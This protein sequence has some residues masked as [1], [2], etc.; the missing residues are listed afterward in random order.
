MKKSFLYFIIA[1]LTVLCAG[2]AQAQIDTVHLFLQDGFGKRGN[3]YGFPIYCNDSLTV[4]DSVISGEFTVSHN[5]AVMDI[6][7]FDTVGTM[8]SGVQ[9]V[10]YYSATKKLAFINSKPISGTGTLIYLTVQVKTNASGTTPLNLTGAMLNEGNPV[11]EVDPGSFRPMDIFINPKN[12][13]QNKVVGDTILF[14]VTGDKTLPL[15]WSVAD[16][17]IALIDSTGRLIGKKIGQ[18]YAKVVD[19]I[20]LSDSSNLIPINSPALNSLTMTIRDTSFVQN[21]TFDLPIRIS[22]VTSLGIISTQWKLNFNANTLVPKAVIT[23][24]ALAQ[25]WG[26]PTVN[27]GTGT[28]DVAMA[29]SDTLTSQ[30]IFAYVRFQ[31]KRFATQSSNLT[32]Q[33]VMFNENINAAIQ[34]GVFTPILGPTITINPNVQVLTRGDTLT[35]FATGGTPPYKWFSSNV[36]I[37][38]VDSLTGKVKAKSR[39]IDTLRAFDVQG[40]DGTAIISINDFLATLPDTTVAI[41]DSVDVPIYVS[42]V[43]GLGILSTQ[44]KI[45]YD[46]TKVRFSQLITSG[47]MSSAM[48]TAVNDSGSVIHMAF[49]GSFPLAGNG[50]F[51]KLRFHHKAPSGPGQ[52]TPLTF[53]EYLNNEN[54]PTVTLKNGKITIFSPLNTNPILTKAM[55]DTTINED[56]QLTFDYDAFDL[57]N[58]TLKF[59]LQNP[60]P[61][62][63]IDSMTGLFNWRPSFTQFGLHTFTLLVTDGKGGSVSKQTNINVNRIPVFTQT[64]PDTIIVVD[65]VLNFTYSAVD[66]DNDNLTFSIIKSPVGATIQSDGIFSWKPS[67]THIGN[68]TI[69]VAVSDGSFI[70][71]DSAIVTVQKINRPPQFVAT[72][73]DISVVVDSILN[74]KYT[75][76]DPDNDNLTFSMMKSPAGATIQPDGTFS[77][78]PSVTQIG[79]DTIIIAVSDGSFTVR[80]SAIVTVQK[81]NRSPQFISVLPDII[82]PVDSV[83][84]FKYAAVDPDN[85]NLV[86]SIVKSLSGATIQNDGLFSWKPSVSQIGKD[87]IIIS[88]SD[89]SFIV[90]DT[91]I[92]TVIGFPT[93]KL[94]QNNFDFGSISFGGSKTLSASITNNGVTPLVILGLPEFNLKPDPNFILDTT[95]VSSIAPGAQKTI[96]IT[97]HPKSVGGHFTAYVFSTNDPK[98]P[99][100]V[101]TANGSAIAKLAV[102][103]KLLVD[104]LHNSSVS[105]KDSTSGVNQLFKFF[106]QS[107]IQISLTGF[108]LRPSGND[109]LLLIAPQKKFTPQEIDSVKT[110]VING[111]LLV[112]LGNSALEGNNAA[113]LNSLLQDSTWTTNL[114]FNSNTVVDDSSNFQSNNFDPLLTTFAD[115]KHPYF[116]N[117]DTLVFFGS[118]SVTVSGTAIPLITTSLK[119]KTIG[120]TS[121]VQPA[122]AGLSKIGKGKI[123]LLGD[124]D[125]WKVESANQQKQPNISIKDNL[126]FAINV[127]SVTEDY[128]V[129]LPN[130]TLNER[131]QLV[132]IPFDLDNADVAS[133]LKGLGEQGPLS[134]RLFGHYDPSTGKYV[135]FPTEKFKSFKRGEAYW[136]ITRGE[137]GL[138]L[139][140]STIVPVQSYYPIKIGPGY[141]MVGN[142]FPYKVSWKN[143]THDSTQNLIWK[144]DGATF[145]AESLAL[146]PFIGYFVKNMSKDSV[147]IYINPEDITGLGKSGYSAA[148]VNEGEWRIGISAGSGKS[149]DEEN[150]AGVAK[151]AKDE[152]D[153]FDVAEPPSSPTD[154]VVVRFQN[155]SWKEQSGS[156]AMDI[157]SISNEGLFWDFDVTT[158]ASQ[159]RV[160]LN[161]TKFGNL[162]NDFEIFVIDKTTERIAQID[163]TYQYEFSMVKNESRRKFRLITGKKDYVEKNTQGIP[164]IAVDYSLMQNYPNPFNPSTQIR[165]A[166]GHSGHVSLDVYNVLGQHVRSLIN[167]IQPIGTYEL[168]WDGKDKTGTHV[169]SGVYFYKITVMSNGEKI[170]NETKKLMLL[171]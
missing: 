171:K 91:A 108:D 133:V 4:A 151:G 18:T 150:Y 145:K 26:T 29:G 124:A 97:Y 48:Q 116:A 92:V 101:L 50:V 107:G 125:M 170:F 70:A 169:S 64:L 129:K 56:Q 54:G 36:A 128:E 157:R 84:N 86:F 87:T 119:G 95:G 147:I 61:G 57:N 46:T 83:L 158:A 49:S 112:A 137:F 134:W 143:S 24:G 7:G 32:L 76:V 122:V 17:S 63:S 100:I 106:E 154:Y 37:A 27:F 121:S 118:A 138:S 35:Y 117:V 22:D 14:S 105:F 135:E 51:A 58:D 162:P 15:F 156:Y 62:M 144:F 142:P 59:S 41:G 90:R 153:S 114:A 40:F 139:G 131:Y 102:T 19:F 99:S 3:F 120:G 33:N 132:S 72:L 75:A 66:P 164:L 25:S 166:L 5:G 109:I 69:I 168:E 1:V 104:T 126:A 110:F 31:V 16:T 159:S 34:N 85:D 67:V 74:F 38:S 53:L 115:V 130:K 12:P 9:N 163:Q 127:F 80:D 20:G 141:S 103:K 152:F 94:S 28:I 42:D 167:K 47:V 44:I 123:L 73:P 55:G 136:L 113:A 79:S 71:R 111:G 21:L 43:T 140:N 96:T 78:K 65:S 155:N 68:D 149:S 11:V 89:G 2:I 13:P 6:I 23:V 146:D 82:F 30:G 77:W 60:S 93:A 88:V 165:Y 52:F 8:L 39:G 161:L 10:I 98:N 160:T 45:G 81:I 148:V